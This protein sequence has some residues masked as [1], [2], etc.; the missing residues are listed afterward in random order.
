MIS[1]IVLVRHVF[2]IRII[3]YRLAANTCLQA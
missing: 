3:E 1:L 2:Y